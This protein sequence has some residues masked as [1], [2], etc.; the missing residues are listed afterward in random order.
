MTG[1]PPRLALWIINR[2]LPATLAADVAG[3]LEERWRKDERGPRW[4]AAWRMLGLATAIGSQGV[5]ERG[6]AGV[7]GWRPGGVMSSLAAVRF[8]IRFAVRLLVRAPLS[9]AAIVTTLALGIG[10]TVSLFAVTHA[11][12]LRPLPFADPD[13]LVAVWETIPSASIFEN[14]PAPVV[15]EHWR[16]RAGSF[17]HLTP[18]TVG[19]VNLTGL[20]RPLRLR[21]LRVAPELLSVLGRQPLLGRD[22]IPDDARGPQ[23]E[24]ALVSHRFWREE[25]GEAHDI[26]GR[27]LR[28]DGRSIEIV[29]V[30]PA[31]VRLFGFDP[32]LW[33][34]L[35]WTPELR[36][37]ESRMLWVIGRLRSGVDPAVASA[38]LD[39]LALDR[40]GNGTGGRA[41]DLQEQTVGPIA[42]D[43]VLLLGASGLVLLIA[44]ANV[45]SLTLA[46]MIA[47][48][49]ELVTRAAL[50]AS[51]LR[52]ARQ[53]LIEG[54]VVSLAGGL[55]GLLLAA[56]MSRTLAAAVP[57]SAVLGPV[58]VWNSAV[59]G[60]AV[61][62]SLLTACLAG[63]IPTWQA[64]TGAAAAALRDGARGATGSR[65]WTLRG[66]VVIEVALA[67]VLLVATGLVLRSFQHLRQID[68]GFRAD[69]LVVAEVPRPADDRHPQ[70]FA[71]LE[72]ALV[73][74]GA[75]GV[76]MSQGL[77]LLAVGAFGSR[78]LVEGTDADAGVLA[79]W[80]VVNGQYYS[81]LGIPIQAGRAF[82]RADAAGATP[83]AIV[84]ESFARRAW[85]DADPIGRRIGWGTLETPLTV[86]GVAGDVRH[87]PTQAPGPHVYMPYT[88]VTSRMPDQIAMR[89][90]L[91]PAPA[92]DLLRQVVVAL[93]PDQPVSRIS[94]GDDLVSRALGR[95]RFQLALFTAFATVAITLAVVG[96]YGVLSFLV[97]ERRREV[98]I[99]LALGATP[100][101][102]RRLWLRQSLVMTGAGLVLGLA[103]SWAGGR[104]VGGL[105]TGVTPADQ[106]TH[107]GAVALIV[108]TAAVASLGPAYRAARVDP[109]VTLSAD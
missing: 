51:R 27:R 39:R 74:R 90:A 40:S 29:G 64:T 87:S 49:R 89:S 95:P 42:G 102:I 19:T 36:A 109:I 65:Q 32:D 22:L 67:L 16:A 105:L 47:R 101:S 37:S 103:A 77:P 25:F 71:D 11:W 80:R 108:L 48:R 34:P 18:L 38:E 30:V 93:D 88:Q 24:V 10:A 54:V 78:F 21:T 73:A 59:S 82:T 2:T 81:T 55:G 107:A 5:R 45:A 53:V 92:I 7:N 69:G 43:V 9:T 75:E 100:A 28:L 15:V 6:R 106:A 83:V 84:S 86:V 61:A 41:V 58:D 26:V 56:W 66:L 91:P 70:F 31:D 3:D 76:A 72:Q 23:A 57:G 79:Y 8:D 12:L 4:W 63:F 68:L 104:L 62:I 1:R 33:M 46:Q 35:A 94:T 99:R 20:E 60:F 96:L 13:R 85:P 44:C 98:G 50:G 97:A 14:T 17:E 52:I